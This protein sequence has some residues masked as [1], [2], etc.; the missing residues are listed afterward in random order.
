MPSKAKLVL[1]TS[2]DGI[3]VRCDPSFPDAWRRAPYQAQIRKWAA[4]GEEDDV[5]VIVIVGQRVILITPTRDFDLGEIGPD[6]R[7]VRDLDGTRVVDVRVV[8]I[9]PKQQS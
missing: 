9:N 3:E 4:S 6:E 2:E 8:K 7:I 1:T 5:T